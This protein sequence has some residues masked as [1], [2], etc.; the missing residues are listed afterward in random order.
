MLSACVSIWT[1]AHKICKAWV[2]I[3]QIFSRWFWSYGLWLN[4]S[5][6][7]KQ[8][9]IGVLR[10]R[11]SENM[12]QIYRRSLMP[13]LHVEI[14]F[15][16]RCSPINLLHIFRIFLSKNTSGW[17]PLN[18]RV[19]QVDISQPTDMN[20][21]ISMNRFYLIEALIFIADFFVFQ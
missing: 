10:K 2:L 19:K 7:Q 15:R 11:C 20:Q 18:Y 16:H 12:Q 17:L 1:K 6:H 8:P 3:N 13:K 9:S 21:M 5:N 4:K 14:A